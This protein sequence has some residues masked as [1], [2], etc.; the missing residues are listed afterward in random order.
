MTIF[1]SANLARSRWQRC[2]AWLIP[3]AGIAS[4]T[5]TAAPSSATGEMSNGARTSSGAPG[6][7]SVA[8]VYSYDLVTALGD[9]YSFG[10]AGY[11]GGEQWRHLSAPIVGGVATPDG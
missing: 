3:P 2:R 9:V 7:P 10:G 4:A 6:G 11:Y 1:R 5:G 8:P